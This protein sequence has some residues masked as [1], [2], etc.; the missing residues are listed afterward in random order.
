M[1]GSHPRGWQLNDASSGGSLQLGNI[2]RVRLRVFEVTASLTGGTGPRM[3]LYPC[4]P[5]TCWG[6]NKK[7][8]QRTF[9]QGPDSILVRCG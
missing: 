2:N 9:C 8:N 1:E 5:Y 4:L 3:L 6:S 7:R